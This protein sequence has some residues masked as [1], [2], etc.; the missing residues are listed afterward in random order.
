MNV[1][2]LTCPQCETPV[3]V[4]DEQLGE[5]IE[6]D[7][8]RQRF[9]ASAERAMPMAPSSPRRSWLGVIALA[10]GLVGIALIGVSLAVPV[11]LG[12][13]PRFSRSLSGPLWRVRP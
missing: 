1:H 10:A 7:Y 8:C 2:R 4:R 5:W 9:I 13:V 3:T 6:C 11:G 12:I